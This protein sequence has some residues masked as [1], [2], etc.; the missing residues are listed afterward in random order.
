MK[1]LKKLTALLT[2][3]VMSAAACA[4]PVS[5]KETV[6]FNILPDQW[7]AEGTTVPKKQSDGS[8]MLKST[9]VNNGGN[10]VGYFS[11]TYQKGWKLAYDFTIDGDCALISIKFINGTPASELPKGKVEYKLT[12]VIANKMGIT[13]LGDDKDNLPG[14]TYKGVLDVSDFFPNGFNKFQHVGVY[15]T[16]KSVTFR[17]LAFETGVDAG[18]VTSATTAA[19]TAA[20][21]QAA[22]TS[23]AAVT[24]TKAVVTSAAGTTATAAAATVSGS[25]QGSSAMPIIIAIIV[26]VVLGAAAAAF[27][28]IRKKKAQPKPDTPQDKN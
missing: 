16:G 22:T 27:F 7:S 23:E 13:P 26:V 10:A 17:K 18:F 2:I 8:W 24:T 14:G 3:A 4:F 1:M 5:A 21:T 11:T 12:E 19:T 15:L 20:T 9:A 25:G 28:I 6:A